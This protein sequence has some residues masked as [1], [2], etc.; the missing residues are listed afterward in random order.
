MWDENH[1]QLNEIRE[2]SDLVFSYSS[3]G[4]SDRDLRP[5]K[6]KAAGKSRLLA[7]NDQSIPRDHRYQEEFQDGRVLIASQE[8]LLWWQKTV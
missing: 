4:V 1:D 8:V 2:D 7:N 3:Q 5:R 6:R